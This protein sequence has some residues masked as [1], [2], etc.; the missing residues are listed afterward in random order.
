[1]TSTKTISEILADR[2]AINEALSTAVRDAV[3]VHARMGRSVPQ[4]DNGHIAWLSPP[5]IF[6]RYGLDEF[7]RELPPRISNQ[8]EQ[9]LP[10]NADHGYTAENGSNPGQ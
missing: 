8:H 9:D 6:A 5:E 4:M 7:G 10:D 3:I 2:T 1:M